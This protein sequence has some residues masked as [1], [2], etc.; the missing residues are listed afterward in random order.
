MEK[1]TKYL[2]VHKP[3]L[4]LI[5]SRV[6]YL[7]ACVVWKGNPCLKASL[8]LCQKQMITFSRQIN[9]QIKPQFFHMSSSQVTTELKYKVN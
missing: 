3:W 1:Q 5:Q 9:H 4:V 6:S 8:S 7:P 2:W